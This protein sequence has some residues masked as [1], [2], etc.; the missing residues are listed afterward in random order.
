[1]LTEPAAA[2]A[3]TP[4]IV[5]LESQLPQ[6]AAPGRLQILDSLC[7]A[8]EPYDVNRALAY[9]QQH[10]QLARKQ[11]SPTAEVRALNNLGRCYVT[12]ADYLTARQLYDQALQLARRTQNADGLAATYN[13][14]GALHYYRNDTAS[15]WSNFQLALSVL[16]QPGVRPQTQVAILNNAS[17]L[18]FET[19]HPGRGERLGEQAVALAKTIQ[20]PEA[21]IKHHLNLGIVALQQQPAVAVREFQE[22]ANL[23]RQ[24][25]RPR[26]EAA[27]LLE[28]AALHLQQNAIGQ[29]LV[30]AHRAR[31]LSQSRHDRERVLG[32][33]NLLAELYAA[34]GQ[35]PTAYQWQ[36]RFQTLN[37]S[38]NA[39]RQL[40][41]LAAWESRYTLRDK[42][43]QIVQLTQHT[44]EQ[45]T[46]NRLLLAG[47]GALGLVLAGGSLLYWQL[48]R[49]R[50]ALA[51]NHA[52][53]H[54]ATTQVARLAAAKDRLYTI[55][56]HDLRGPV[57]AFVGV[58]ELIEFYHRENN[59]E[60]LRNLPGLVRQSASSLN[61]L[62]D[63]LL[64]W[65]VMQSGELQLQLEAVEAGEVLRE[66]AGIYSTLAHA[67]NLTL[68]V[69][70]P[71]TPLYSQVDRNMLRT[72]LRNL[73]GNAIKFT[74]V[75][76]SIT[77]SAFAAS[78]TEI[79]FCVH[80]TGAG[81]S[82][83]QVEQ[84]MAPLAQPP[85]PA[86]NRTGTGLGLV[87]CRAFVARLQ[88]RLHVA[89]VPGTGTTVQV[90]LPRA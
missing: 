48:R 69:D 24:N 64:H 60:G 34:A 44:Q 37:D 45:T 84:L 58:A 76:G 19:G 68:T 11:Q 80:D 29:G 28:L 25:H 71:A 21:A 8:W 72:I 70:A 67:R 89:S 27:A 5:R 63:N 82:A 43:Q 26:H 81:M 9:G 33:Y 10:L 57:T 42:Q 62:L 6:A 32:A 53:L 39:R 56:A 30:E 7:W 55:V 4:T 51:R 3:P 41:T 59:Q 88:G 66:C 12:V 40:A 78:A 1:M 90:S 47:L 38:L 73:T 22:S 50:Q 75:G 86:H 13:R 49:S 46:R 20:D 15:A 77:L 54:S 83:T 85:V 79:V 18:L 35:Y 61:H 36:T 87:L 65:A 17:D 74:P 16:R 31:E 23:A 14:L 2:Q 52:A